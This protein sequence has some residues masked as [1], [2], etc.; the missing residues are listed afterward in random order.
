MPDSVSLDTKMGSGREVHLFCFDTRLCPA[1]LWWC[2]PEPWWRCPERWSAPFFLDT[3]SRDAY[4][5][6]FPC[7]HGQKPEAMG[8]CEPVSPYRRRRGRAFWPGGRNSLF[9]FPSMSRGIPRP[10]YRWVL[11]YCRGSRGIRTGASS[12]P[13][14][15]G[16]DALRAV[17]Q[18]AP[19]PRGKERESPPLAS[20]HPL[21]PSP[22]GRWIPP[23][24]AVCER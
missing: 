7:R 21:M 22:P 13:R 8:G 20:K 19:P 1:L 3:R 24:L 23:F 17:R 4:T 9:L 18:S 10:P 15:L 16:P 2:L 12:R 5:P 14:F 11:P 6:A